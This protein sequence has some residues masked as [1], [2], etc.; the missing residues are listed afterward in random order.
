MSNKGFDLNQG[1]S[2]G[3]YSILKIFYYPEKVNS[4]LNKKVISPLYVRLKC[5][6]RCNNSCFYCIYNPK[7]SDIHP[8]SNR[9]DEIPINKINQILDDFEKMGIKA[10][11]LSGG[12]EPLI[13][14]NISKILKEIIKKK[15]RFS[16]ITNGLLL[17]G[18]IAKL[19]YNA[20]WIRISLDYPNSKLYSKIR[21][22]DS[23]NFYEVI[24]NI[25][26]FSKNKHKNCDLGV[27][28]VVHHLNY[29][30]L[31]DIA[32]L[33]KKL[34]VDNLRF[35]PLWKRNF[36]KYHTPFKNE[37]I[38]Q[39]NKAKELQDKTF[40]VGSSYEK[41]FERNTGG[42]K[43]DYPRC[44]Y[45]EIV[46]AIAADQCVYTCHNNAYEPY[47][48]IGSIKRQ[49]F[50]KMWFSSKTKKFFK[51]FNPK[52]VCNHECSNDEKNR[53]LNEFA[54]CM[55]EGVVEYI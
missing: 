36:L 32:K 9:T 29:K 48:K 22:I 33:C 31:I 13:H 44:F 18:K 28:C 40:S 49:S 34:G 54:N 51:N 7:F 46:P 20:D 11:T 15:I 1:I 25:K 55:G 26:D 47:G 17:K 53:I 38:K 2:G 12:G 6:N 45:M 10:I 21:N 37:A 52:K 4:M 19:L 39:I 24:T 3:R 27:N 5:S 50:K 8:L 35:A 16:V 30:H 42:E 14:P 43:R 41:Y 23:S